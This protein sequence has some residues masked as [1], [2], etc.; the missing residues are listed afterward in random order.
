[1]IVVLSD[2]HAR[3]QPQLDSHLRSAIEAAELV[4]HAGDFTTA[5]V[6]S[7]FE[8][9][10]EE[11]V[12]VTGNRDRSPLREK[13]PAETTTTQGELTLTVVH[14]HRHDDTSLSMLGRQEGADVLV[15]GHSHKPVIERMGE[16]LLLNPGSHADPRGNQPAYATIEQ[17]DETTTISLKTPAGE[18]LEAKTI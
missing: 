4:I 7:Y 18:R 15:T 9:L 8:G 6:Y 14:G 17:E 3:Q 13:L 10:A 2:T 5:P 11:L 16:Q 12:A 1:M